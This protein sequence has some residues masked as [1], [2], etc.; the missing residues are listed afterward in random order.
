MVTNV[1]DLDRCSKFIE[2]VRWLRFPKVK[3]R[4]VRKFSNLIARNNKMLDKNRLVNNNTRQV[5]NASSDNIRQANN[6]VG[7][8]NNRENHAKDK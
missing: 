5:S 3:E 1:G 7:S 8:N 6:I 4:Q 2:E